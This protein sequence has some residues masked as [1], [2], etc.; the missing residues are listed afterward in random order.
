MIYDA[1]VLGLG[2]MGSAALAHLAARGQR[3][4]GLE[5]FARGHDL[6]ASSG[7][8]RIIRMAYYED[9]AYVPLLRRAYELW[10][11]LGHGFKFCPVIGEI[12]ADLALAGTTRHPIDFLRLARIAR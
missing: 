7:Q 1:V 2:G 10:S 12:V 9:P 8:S 5:R 4:L 3:V 6:G 11:K